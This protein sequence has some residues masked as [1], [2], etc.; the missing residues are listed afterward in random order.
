MKVL[1]LQWVGFVGSFCSLS[2]EIIVACFHMVVMLSEIQILL[3]ISRRYFRD[4]V[5]SS[6]WRV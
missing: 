6:L 1:G 4:I 2:I 3:C 5:R